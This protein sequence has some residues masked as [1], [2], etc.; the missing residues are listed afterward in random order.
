[1]TYRIRRARPDEAPQIAAVAREAWGATYSGIIPEETQAQALQQWYAVDRL[2]QQAQNPD[3][4]F[5]VAEAPDGGIAGIAFASPRKEPRHAEL[6]RFYVLPGHQRRGI[7]RQMLDAVLA[8]LQ[9]MHLYVQVEKENHL[10]RRAYEALGFTFVREYD[11]DLFGFAT[12]A[13]E[14]RLDVTENAGGA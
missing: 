11:D 6:W 8:A 13:V 5:V 4:A 1:V 14:L 3:A 10:G 2:A 12:K 7:G 9:P